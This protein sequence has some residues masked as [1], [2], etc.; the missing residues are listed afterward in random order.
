MC[1]RMNM[2]CGECGGWRYCG[3][4]AYNVWSVDIVCGKDEYGVECVEDE[5]GVWRGCI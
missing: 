4:D 2:V 3:K 5:N 1:G